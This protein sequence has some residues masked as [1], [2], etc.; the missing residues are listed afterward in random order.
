MREVVRGMPRVQESQGWVAAGVI[1]ARAVVVVAVVLALGCAST[2]KRTYSDASPPSWPLDH[3]SWDAMLQAYTRDGVV[4]Y[5]GFAQDPRLAEYLQAI[6]RVEIPAGAPNAEKIAYYLNA[7][8]AVVVQAI[9]DG[10]SPS[11]LLGRYAFFIG[12]PYLFANESISLLDVETDRIRTLGDPR[13]HFALVCASLSCPKI[14]TRGYV[15]RDLD[16]QLHRDAIRFIRDPERT[17]L[18][19]SARVA[20]ISKIF[21]WY[22]EDFEGGVAA[23]IGR[24]TKDPMDASELES[25]EFDL[26]YEPYDWNLN[27]P[28]PPP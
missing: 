23:Y 18:D 10:G 15:A 2:P 22:E 21:K 3:S 6:A 9:L 5:P 8:N 27:G 26:E 11:S 25:G 19:R 14:W 1:G 7:Y 20:H 13:I 24:Y 12:T 28:P 4:D 17:R 16:T